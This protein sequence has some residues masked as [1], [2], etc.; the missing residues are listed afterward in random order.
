MIA[1][2]F[3][4]YFSNIGPKLSEQISHPRNNYTTYIK[5][6]PGINNSIF[7]MPTDQYEVLLLSKPLNQKQVLVLIK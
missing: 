5:K 2:E 3:C 4:K 1:K 7:L 6:A